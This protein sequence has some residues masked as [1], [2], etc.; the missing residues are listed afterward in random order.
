MSTHLVI[1][2][3]LNYLETNLLNISK[4]NGYN[5][6]ISKV[7][8]T[9]NELNN[10]KNFPFIRYWTDDETRSGF[11]G[12]N[13]L[14]ENETVLNIIATINSEIATKNEN[15]LLTNALSISEDIQAYFEG[16][17]WITAGKT[18]GLLGYKF[19]YGS[20]VKLAI[21]N[22]SR[23]YLKTSKVYEIYFKLNL[24]YHQNLTRTT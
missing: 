20:V 22:I 23:P 7:Y 17:H 16:G 2:D 11:N 10:E 9:D 5:N 3:I 21:T 14:N 8:H 13:T 1:I 18:C 15:T 4:A 12:N 6:D 19:T 24:N